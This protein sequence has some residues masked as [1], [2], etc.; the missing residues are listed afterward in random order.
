MVAG[1]WAFERRPTV[2][3]ESF[4]EGM[5]LSKR[6]PGAVEG[7][8]SWAAGWAGGRLGGWP[9]SLPACPK[10]GCMGLEPTIR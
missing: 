10:K 3:I 5:A 9:K 6:C 8:C 4:R 1:W 7:A 2:L